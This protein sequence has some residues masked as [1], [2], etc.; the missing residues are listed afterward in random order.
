MSRKT[1]SAATPS[2]TL[3]DF[4]RVAKSLADEARVRTL[5]ALAGGELCLCQI[6]DLVE[7]APST[8]SKHVN[9]LY[10]VGLVE[11]RKQGRWHY[12][13]LA[14]GGAAEPAAG[15]LGW[16]REALGGS[17]EAAEIHAAQCC[18]RDKDLAELTTCY[19]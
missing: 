18:V 1:D 4:V 14:G 10:A 13:R 6:V 3:Q 17:G 19:A 15:A 5:L 12:F 2:P 8:V 9:Q 11:R 7:L 16:L